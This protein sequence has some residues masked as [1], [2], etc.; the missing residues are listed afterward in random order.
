MTCMHMLTKSYFTAQRRD[1]AE[2]D[3]TSLF[4]N[5]QGE[6]PI[7]TSFDQGPF[8]PRMLY[9][10]RKARRRGRTASPGALT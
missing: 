7:G 1:V 4:G 8:L 9:K 6:S 2:P 5:S 3:I 10:P